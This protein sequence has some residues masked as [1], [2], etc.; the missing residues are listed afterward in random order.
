MH[1][2]SVQRTLVVALALCVVCSVVVAS[3]AVLLSPVQQ[4]NQLLDKR[5]NILIAAGL[6]TPAEL[7][8][9]KVDELFENIELKGV[10]IETGKYVDIQ[11]TFSIKEAS[12][13][14]ARS[15]K[16]SAEE[17][18]ADIRRQPKVMPVYLAKGESGEIEKII[19]PV[20]GYGLWSTLYGFMALE[21]DGNTVAG[22]G[23]YQHAETP[24]LGGEVD[25]PKW[26]AQ[27][28]GKKVAKDGEV[29]VELAKGGVDENTPNSQYKVDALSGATLTSRG[30]TNLL[31][32][33][34]G[35]DGYGPFL[36]QFRQ[37]V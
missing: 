17:D 36:K 21:S 28:P 33:W 37:E 9:E 11:P 22:L 7:S 32:F 34:L 35:E 18:L 5:K 24:G 30:V 23:F 27:W 25:N 6:A 4:A 31:R 19:L 26:K 3:A 12:K 8:A 10:E 16:L 2:D 1:K 15:E 20:H 29:L 14:P 13:D